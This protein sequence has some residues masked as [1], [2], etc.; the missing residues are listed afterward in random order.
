MANESAERGSDPVAEGL[1][2]VSSSDPYSELIDRSSLSN[3]DVQQIG[4]LMKVFSDLRDVERNVSEASQRYMKLTTQEMRAIH[5]LIVAGNRDTT[6][7][8]SSIATHLGISAASTTKLLN[9]L[10]RGDH[11]ARR[12]H[13]DDRRA[14]A[15]EVTEETRSVAMETVGRQQS[16]RFHAGARLSADEREIVIRFLQDMASEL[17]RAGQTWSDQAEDV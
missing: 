8:P 5:Y 13:P 9:R 7:T 1:Y 10:E 14:F 17:S 4:R 11:V 15:I 3:D 2:D 6:A 16:R 12:I